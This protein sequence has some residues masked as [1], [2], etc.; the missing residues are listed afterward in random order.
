[1]TKHTTK[2]KLLVVWDRNL[3]Y[4]GYFVV[5]QYPVLE[6]STETLSRGKTHH[7]IEVGL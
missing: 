7:Y 5:I 4:L 2:K 1:M 3:G 6:Q